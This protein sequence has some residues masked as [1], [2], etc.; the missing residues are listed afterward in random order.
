[1]A[2]HAGRRPLSRSVVSR[3][4]LVT[5]RPV[6]K[7]AWPVERSPYQFETSPPGV[8]AIG[9]VRHQ[10][11][12]GVTAAVYEGTTAVWSAKEYLAEE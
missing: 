7:P 11:P 1:V 6:I 4:R 5:W 9:D 3:P 12:R 10:A 8:F 2:Q